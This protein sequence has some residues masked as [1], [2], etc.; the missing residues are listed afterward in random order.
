MNVYRLMG[1]AAVMAAVLFTGT[2]VRAAETGHVTQVSGEI[3]WVDVNQGKLQLKRDASPDTGEVLEYR[4]TKNDT[5]VTN[6]A[7]KKFLTVDDLQ[8][9]Q[10]VTI[11]VI[12]GKEDGIIPKI[13]TEPVVVTD[14]EVALGGLQAIDLTNGTLVLEERPRIGEEG[15]TRLSQFVFSPNDLVIMQSP[16]M[17]PVQMQLNPGDVLKIEYTVVNGQRRLRSVTR[18]APKAAATSTTTTTTVTTTQAP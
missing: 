4:I 9:G 2:F 3:T 12:D 5:R 7:D 8:A 16:G 17:Q 15:R 1:C 14:Y 18:Y 13:T 10:H 6:P 11:D